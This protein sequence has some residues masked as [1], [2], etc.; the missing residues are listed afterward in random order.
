M[1]R[2]LYVC[3]EYTTYEF[4]EIATENK[5]T[6]NFDNFVVMTTYGAT[7]YYKVVKLAIFFS[8]GWL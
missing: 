1:I 6:F 7:S 4:M 3:M 2:F 8:V 5:K